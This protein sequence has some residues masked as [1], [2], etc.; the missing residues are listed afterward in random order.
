MRKPALA[1]ALAVSSDSPLRSQPLDASQYSS[2]D[3]RLRL[4]MSAN[5]APLPRRAKDPEYTP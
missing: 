4:L 1:K 3:E 5:P 2:N